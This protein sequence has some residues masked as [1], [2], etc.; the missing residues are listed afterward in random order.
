MTPSSRR[1]IGAVPVVTIGVGIVTAAVSTAAIIHPPLTAAMV[2]SGE[3]VH[4]GEWWRLVT[5]VLVQPDGWGQFA[6]NLAGIAVVGAVL[7]QLVRRWLW[8]AVFL[9]AGIGSVLVLTLVTPG[10]H[11]GGSSDCVAG[12]IGALAALRFL[13]GTT[14]GRRRRVVQLAAIAYSVFFCAYLT[15]LDLGGVWPAILAGDLAVAVALTATHRFETNRTSAGVFA[16][17]VVAGAVMTVRGDGHGIGL[18]A[19]VLLAVTARRAGRGLIRPSS[20]PALEDGSTAV[21][22]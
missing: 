14:V 6:F 7:E 19:G 4:A 18:L 15:A 1:H 17:V 11:D 3:L 20:T 13:D 8:L 16:L 12:L 21:R 5:P 9:T 22:P 10:D 2:R